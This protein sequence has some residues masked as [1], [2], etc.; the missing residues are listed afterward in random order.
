MRFVRLSS[1]MSTLAYDPRPMTLSSSKSWMEYW[2]AE[3]SAPLPS[4]LMASTFWPEACLASSP[5]WPLA[6]GCCRRCVAGVLPRWLSLMSSFERMVMS[7]PFMSLATA[8]RMPCPA[9]GLLSLLCTELPPLATSKVPVQ[10]SRYSLWHF[11]CTISLHLRH[12]KP[13]RPR[14]QIRSR[15]KTQK[16]FRLKRFAWYAWPFTWYILRHRRAPRRYIDSEGRYVL[17]K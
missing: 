8:V 10:Q 12:L 13:W 1:T 11:L 2:C 16:A 6:P 7:A 17:V 3:L 9:C 15:Q 14:P 4:S 5:K